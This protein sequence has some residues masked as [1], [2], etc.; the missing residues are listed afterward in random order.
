MAK[1]D[2]YRPLMLL[3]EI[4]DRRVNKDSNAHVR[5][6]I[7]RMIVYSEVSLNIAP[8]GQGLAL[9]RPLN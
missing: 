3:V 7:I 1:F 8:N 6:D 2:L 9:C 5:I 4:Q